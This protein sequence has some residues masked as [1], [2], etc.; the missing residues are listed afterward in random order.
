M[1]KAAPQLLH[2]VTARLERLGDGPNGKAIDA[3]ADL[4]VAAVDKGGVIQ[5]FG[6]GHSQ[7]FVMEIVGRAGGLIPT[8]A[9]ALRDLVL[10]GDR[11]REVLSSGV[12][13]RD[14]S[15]VDELWRLSPVDPD[16]VFIIASNSGVNGSIV[17]MALAIKEHGH[18]L[19][20]VTSRDHTTAVTP[21]HPSGKRLSE[22][23]DV[24]ID[25]FAPYG[26][27]TLEIDSPNGPIGV[28]A[29]SSITGAFI[30]QLLTIAV[31]ERLAAAGS[32]PPI[33]LSANTPGGDEHNHALEA[34]YQGRIR[35]SA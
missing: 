18:P 28:G 27:T 22:I 5:A 4:M 10:Y 6:T 32:T 31:A 14:P 3:A 23:A 13:E 19:I 29:V 7:A 26:D 9:I 12:L 17:G 15:I 35:R 16:D 34:L 2:E 24:V 21:K 33:Y 1:I 11:D 8:T 25:N 20:A 30:A